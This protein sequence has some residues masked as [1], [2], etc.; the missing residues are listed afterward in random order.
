MPGS[1]FLDNPTVADATKALGADSD[2]GV[3]TPQSSPP[4]LSPDIRGEE[5]KDEITE[6][7]VPFEQLETPPS[8]TTDY[9]VKKV[10]KPLSSIDKLGSTLLLQGSMS[11]AEPPLFLLAD[12]TGSV[13]SYIQLPALEGGRR[14]YGV[15]SPFVRDPSAFTVDVSVG[16]LADAFITSIRK[17]QPVGPYIIG[18]SSLGAI[19]AFEVSRRLLNAGETV[20]ELLLIANAA[21]VSAPANLKD[22]DISTE[23]I[24]E[25]GIFYGTGRKRPTTISARQKKHLTASVR[26]H[27][28]Y[29]PQGFT[30]THRP[31]HTTLVI[32]SKGLGEGASAIESPLTPWIHASWGSSETLG[33][34]GLVGEIHSIHRQDIDSFSLLKYPNVSSSMHFTNIF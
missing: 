13:S 22:L 6:S 27:V 15:E 23:M 29:E 3:S 32:A 28:L 18:G 24:D 19:H 5:I 4:N 25:S 11:S 9:K 21:P 14:I 7:S 31:V 12:G 17:I 16:D 26:S 1:F 8:I 30:Q 2:T 20:S 34:D 10:A 33:W